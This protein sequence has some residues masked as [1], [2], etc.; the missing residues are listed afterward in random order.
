MSNSITISGNLTADPEMQFSPSGVG[1]ARFTIASNRKWK[2][3]NDEWQE[4]TAFFRG[5]A[6]RELAE[7]MADSLSKGDR[8]I[9]TGRLD[10]NEWEDKE[11]NKRSELQF[12]VYEIGPSLKY[13]TAVVTR[14]QRQTTGQPQTAAPPPAPRDDYGPDEAPF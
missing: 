9:A 2:D 8:V 11:G 6:W 12:N 4:D 5:T 7:H 10:Q 14:A 3:Q 1:F 13:A